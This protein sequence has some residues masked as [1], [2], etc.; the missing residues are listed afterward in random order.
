VESVRLLSSLGG[1]P[2]EVGDNGLTALHWAAAY[3]ALDC[4]QALVE[5]GCDVGAMDVEGKT[6]RERAQD[7]DEVETA[8]WLGSVENGL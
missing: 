3:G 8:E 2:S 6:P 4:C 1:D 7:K 5:L